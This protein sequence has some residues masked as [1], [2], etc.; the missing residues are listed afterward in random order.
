MMVVLTTA[1]SGAWRHYRE[2]AVL[3]R[4]AVIMGLCSL[5]FALGGATLSTHLPPVVLK[6]GFGVVILL[7]GIRMVTARQLPGGQPY[8]TNPWLWAAWAVP[9]GLVAGVFGVGG[10][11]VMIPV[12]V[13][14]LR[15]EMH[16]AV[17]T[18]LGAMIFASIGGL[19]GYIINGLGVAGRLPYSLGYVN[20]F[21]WLLLVAPA[22][23]MAQVGAITAHRIPRRPL[24]LIFNIGQFYIGLKMTGVFERLGWPL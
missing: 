8:N 21:S 3:W 10:G 9:V 16:Y 1:I 6:T 2:K 17:G 23:V 18:S 11:V 7:S 24:M 13:L 14:A 22:A 4:E 5:V 19:T 15:C 20:G 12:L